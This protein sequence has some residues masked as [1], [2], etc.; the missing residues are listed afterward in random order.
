MNI[1][2]F[3]LVTT[4]SIKLKAKEYIPKNEIK[5]VVCIV[6]GYAEHQERYIH[7]AK[8]FSENNLVVFTYD[9]RSSGKSP[10]KRGYVKDY[11]LLLNDL[12][13]LIK[14]TQNKYN[15]VPLFIY[16]HSLGGG[17]VINYLLKRDVSL[18]KAAIITSPWLLL[19][20]KPPIAMLLLAKVGNVL[21]P[22]F[23]IPSG[24][25]VNDLSN[26]KKVG[27][28]YKD[29]PLTYN[30]ITPRF[31][32]D[33]YKAGIWASKNA[34]K[35]KIPA[36]ISHGTNDNITSHKASAQFANQSDFVEIK[37]WKGMKHEL[38][39]DI[40]KDEVLTFYLNWLND[41]IDN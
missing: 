2:D 3:D 31:F 32:I 29:D 12:Q 17:L 26:D 4:D 16:G 28:A 41:K 35:L 34:E 40:I 7:V 1:T 15:N 30:V 8:L 22:S 11:D 14:I 37:I 39:N 33:T 19:T 27:I 18:I 38:H 5:G 20:K 21:F 9:Q 13:S 25:D 6:H 36:L 24:L 23:Q 10:G